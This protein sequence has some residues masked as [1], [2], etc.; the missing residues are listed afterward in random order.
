ML[1]SFIFAAGFQHEVVF[2]SQT[3]SEKRGEF[4]QTAGELSPVFSPI[5]SGQYIPMSREKNLHIHQVTSTDPKVVYTDG[6]KECIFLTVR[7]PDAPEGFAVHLSASCTLSE[8]VLDV[9]HQSISK[10]NENN[11]KNANLIVN[12]VS[13]IICNLTVP[14]LLGKLRDWGINPSFYHC[15]DYINVVNKGQINHIYNGT[16]NQMMELYIQQQKLKDGISVSYDF[17][18]NVTKV[19][20]PLAG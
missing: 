5:I 7:R 8:E 10:L 15:L 20:N 1:F 9:I 16:E 3:F 4:L 6:L 17:D 18:A 12:C 13:M 2:N 19:F 14:I 11:N